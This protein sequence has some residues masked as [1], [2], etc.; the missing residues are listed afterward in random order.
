MLQQ[1]NSRG[2]LLYV[3]VADAGYVYSY[4]DLKPAGEITQQSW[5]GNLAGSDPNNGDM[6]FAERAGVAEGVV[7][8][9]SHGGQLLTTIM[10]PNY[11]YYVTTTDCAFDPTTNGLAITYAQYYDG[12]APKYYVAVYPTLS[13]KP[14][15]YSELKFNQPFEAVYDGSGDL[16]IAGC[17]ANGY[18]FDELP[19]GGRKLTELSLPGSLGQCCLSW[20]DLDWDG[21]YLALVGW[22]LS[23]KMTIDRLAISNGV[24]TIAGTTTLEGVHPR[25]NN[26][27]QYTI[28]G[29]RVIGPLPKDQSRTTAP[30]GIWHYPA[31]GK[32]FRTLH[33]SLGFHREYLGAVIVS[34]DP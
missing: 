25:R 30:L 28:V 31:G 20:L 34:A 7:D 17:C 13:A 19:K 29:D 4:P 11:G 10:P 32:P 26:D 14:K 12:G 5:F 2:D 6:C 18:V 24:V 33:V 9:Y 21:K 22:S 15:T 27:E 3:A 23:F 1:T 16:F 8:V